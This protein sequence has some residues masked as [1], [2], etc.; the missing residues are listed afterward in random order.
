M[1]QSSL[2]PFYKNTSECIC[3]REGSVCFLPPHS[4]E[5]KEGS[6]LWALPSGTLSLWPPKQ[7]C[8]LYLH[9]HLNS[10][11]MTVH[12]LYSVQ[13]SKKF[14]V[15]LSPMLAF[16]CPSNPAVELEILGF[17]YAHRNH[18]LPS[19]IQ[20]QGRLLPKQMTLLSC[21]YQEVMHWDPS[22]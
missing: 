6:L 3:Q 10:T 20:L 19:K 15:P 21:L 11:T 2:W 17:T 5:N 22:W 14:P 9:L 1:S 7:C 4:R 18:P 12:N 13:G 16:S 8:L